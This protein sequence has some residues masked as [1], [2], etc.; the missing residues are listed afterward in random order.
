MKLSHLAGMILT[1]LAFTA[2]TSCST[3]NKAGSK[4]KD[5]WQSVTSADHKIDDK[6]LQTKPVLGELPTA[7]L[8]P[9]QTEVMIERI[10]Y[11]TWYVE[12]VG[13]MTVSTDL[14]ME[15]RPT[16]TFDSTAVNPFI[17]K[18]YAYTGCN[19]LN[20]DV[21]LT[22]NNKL[23]RTSEFAATMR[24][25]PDAVYEQP[26]IEAFNNLASYKLERTGQ[27][28][29]RMLFYDYNKSNTMVLVKTDND[30]LN[31]AWDVVSIGQINLKEGDMPE[32]MQLVIDIPQRH[33]H[34][35]TGCNVLNGN[36]EINPEVSGSISF[37]NCFTTRMACPNAGLEQQLTAAL[38]RVVAA[39]ES[40]NGDLLLL[41]SAGNTAI[42]LRRATLSHEVD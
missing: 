27:N 34:G 25:C 40:K 24:L 39:K 6:R 3:I 4:V 11:G 10:I 31:G 5:A 21:A 18:I 12:K 17:L 22:L 29:Y 20:G 23:S 19:H 14:D 16:V 7:D 35:N 38:S 9:I 2:I 15:Q 32:T 42:K 8:T 37:S 33:L 1:T 26:M 13:N 28:D 36:I 41:D 30:Y